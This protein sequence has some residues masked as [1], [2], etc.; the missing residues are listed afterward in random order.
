MKKIK[1]IG[2]T[3]FFLSLVFLQVLS[4]PTEQERVA[5]WLEKNVWPPNWQ[6]ESESYRANKIEREKEIMQ[7]PGADERWENWMQFTQGQMVPKFT[8]RG[9]D[10]IDT[11]PEVHAKL[12]NAVQAAIDDIDSIPFEED[13]QA[14]YGDFPPKFLDITS[15]AWEVIEELKEVNGNAVLLI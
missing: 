11:P 3:I 13:T 8:Q 4:R 10:L 1:M 6:E 5:L 7:I 15:M 12:L 14:I 9:F 2:K